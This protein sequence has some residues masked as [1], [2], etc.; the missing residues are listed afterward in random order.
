M[1]I[2]ISAKKIS[3]ISKNQYLTVYLNATTDIKASAE[4]VGQ[5]LAEA[6]LNVE[7]NNRSRRLEKIFQAIIGRFP[8]GAVIKD[9]DVLFNPAYEIDVLRVLTTAY[10]KR[11]FS[12]IWPGGYT[13]EKLFYSEAQ[14]EDYKEYAVANYDILCVE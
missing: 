12:L 3:D 2:I 7:P 14:Y 5:L 1:G 6:L 4:S 9:I 11:P 10:R 8:S 13:N